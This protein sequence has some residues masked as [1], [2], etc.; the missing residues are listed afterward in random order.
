[1]MPELWFFLSLSHCS[2][3]Y[4]IFQINIGTEETG[5]VFLEILEFE[6]LPDDRI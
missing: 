5:K 3:L 1:M 6:K 2:I 4:L